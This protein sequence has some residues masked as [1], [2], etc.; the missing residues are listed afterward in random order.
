MGQFESVRA[1]EKLG[2]TPS[3][4]VRGNVQVPNLDTGGAMGQ[5]LIGGLKIYDDYTTKKANTEFS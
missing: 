5:A 2:F 1:R 3:T 4:A